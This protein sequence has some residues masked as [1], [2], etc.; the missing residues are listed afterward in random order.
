MSS[1]GLKV[2]FAHELSRIN[3]NDVLALACDILDCGPAY[4]TKVATSS[5]GKYH[6]PDEAG[7]GSMVL[8]TR[9]AVYMA[10]ELCRMGNVIGI[11]R[12]CLLAAMVVYDLFKRG[13]NDKPSLHTLTEYPAL[14]RPQTQHLADRPHYRQIMRLVEVHMGQWGPSREVRPETYLEWLAH[15]ADYVVSRREVIV[16]V[17]E[18]SLE[19]RQNLACTIHERCLM[20]KDENDE[21]F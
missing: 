9:R 20:V 8:H 17:P 2:V 11:E 4:F 16:T 18:C 21:G 3:D 6:P 14:V 15:I 1:E 5:S 13:V 19:L 7:P 10:N 12:D